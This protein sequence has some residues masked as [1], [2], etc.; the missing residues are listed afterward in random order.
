MAMH[1]YMRIKIQQ[2]LDERPNLEPI[3]PRQKHK[4]KDLIKKVR[5]GQGPKI[6]EEI[7]ERRAQLVYNQLNHQSITPEDIIIQFNTLE[8]VTYID[9][10]THQ[11]S[12]DE[13]KS[14]YPYAHVTQVSND[15]YVAV[16]HTY[17]NW[18]FNL[19]ESSEN[20]TIL[21]GA[22]DP[23]VPEYTSFRLSELKER[24]KLKLKNDI[25][26]YLYDEL[27]QQAKHKYRIQQIDRIKE[28]IQKYLT[29]KE[30][31]TIQLINRTIQSNKPYKK[32]FEPTNRTAVRQYLRKELRRNGDFEE[33][34]H[35]VDTFT[36]GYDID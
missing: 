25:L 5:R 17:W 1:H 23:S 19:L 12:T 34:H 13:V 20:I 11:L 6:K 21:N 3:T 26:E 36:A 30:Q 31:K 35:K 2:L 27:Y 9:R 7:I 28:N 4:D 22:Y 24:F 33:L 18:R 29:N 10:Y 32:Y 8:P 15:D 16:S 14:I